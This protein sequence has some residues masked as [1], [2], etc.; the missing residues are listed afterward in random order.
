M[1]EYVVRVVFHAH[2]CPRETEIRA[3]RLQY[4]L[5]V[6]SF[7]SQCKRSVPTES[8]GAVPDLQRCVSSPYAFVIISQ[9]MS[10]SKKRPMDWDAI[11]YMI[12]D[13]Q[14][15][16]RITDDWD[17]RLFATYGQVFA[18]SPLSPV[19]RLDAQ[20]PFMLY[21]DVVVSCHLRSFFPIPRRL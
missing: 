11:N 13:V 18:Y 15:G 8:P 14:Y 19:P 9:S 2:N 21:T 4:P 12:C 3:S 10:E 5:R 17:R 6:Q 1:E 7:R 20:F 16:G